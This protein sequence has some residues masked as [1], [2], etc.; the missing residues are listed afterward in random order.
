MRESPWAPFS[1]IALTVPLFPI[2]LGGWSPS[3]SAAC[4]TPETL[5]LVLGALFQA[6]NNNGNNEGALEHR[7]NGSFQYLNL[8]CSRQI[9]FDLSSWFVP[10]LPSAEVEETAICYLG[11]CGAVSVSSLIT[12]SQSCLCQDRPIIYYPLSFCKAPFQ[13]QRGRIQG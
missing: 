2:K 7:I 5:P 1:L 12:L 4:S 10:E 3:A 9:L 13:G 6:M 11:L 8:L